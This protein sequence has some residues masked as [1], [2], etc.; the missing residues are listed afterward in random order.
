MRTRTAARARTIQSVDRALGILRVFSI[1][2]PRLSLTEICTLADLNVSTGSRLAG[3][4]LKSGFLHRDAMSGRFTI[5]AAVIEL[6]MIAASSSNVR[7]VA[8]SI[9]EDLAVSCRETASLAVF[10][11]REVINIDQVASIEPVRYAGWIG[12]HNP[13]HCTSGGRVFLAFAPPTFLDGVIDSGLTAY[14]PKTTTDP[15]R[16]R[17]EVAKVRDTG[18][19]IVCEEFD[20]GLSAV[21][22]PIFDRFHQLVAI[23]GVSVPSF[24][25]HAD[26][27]AVICQHTKQAAQDV[28]QRLSTVEREVK[29]SLV[30][31]DHPIHE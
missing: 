11:G 6:A 16:L 30:R 10:D 29:A 14:T 2:T 23:I 24:R 1:D 22:A 12:R 15:D 4:L 9:L 26:R 3:S 18:L 31:R 19:A 8:H 7:D 20:E 13:L 17:A 25:L 5:G 21:S 28:S 27:L